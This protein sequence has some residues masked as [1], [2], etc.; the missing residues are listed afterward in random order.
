M[1]PIPESQQIQRYYDYYRDKE[2][3]FTK[4][5]LHCLRIDPIQIFVKCGG[6]QWPC[7]INSTSF[8][9][10]KII[11]GSGSGA[12][13]LMEK[14]K[15]LPV[16]VRYCFINPDNSPLSFFINGHVTEITPFNNSSDLVLITVTFSQQPPDVLIS[17]LGKFIDTNENFVRRKEDRII[18]TKEVLRR[19]GLEKEETIVS[20]SDVPRRC[21]LRDISFSGAKV[22]CMGIPKFLQNKPAAIK[23]SFSEPPLS[24]SIPGVI[25][26]AETLADRKD[27][28]TVHIAFDEAQVPMAYKVLINEF[29]MNNQK[30][31]LE[32]NKANEDHQAE[33]KAALTEHA[34]LPEIPL[35]EEL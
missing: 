20:I 27:I 2:I 18:I 22:I 25:K 32:L 35:A 1:M 24:L 16:S 30:M 4:E 10:A 13:R 3:A 7:I 8:Q 17:R 21:V 15:E 34:D 19:L 33:R 5:T 29:L 9:L 28:V 23:L 6:G 11:I 12:Y 14:Q 31:L 26:N